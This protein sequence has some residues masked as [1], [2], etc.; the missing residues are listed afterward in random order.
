MEFSFIRFGN[1]LK[2]EW[3]ENR[4]LYLLGLAA[5]LVLL[6]LFILLFALAGDLNVGLQAFCYFVGLIMGGGILCSTLF[7]R[8]QN[9]TS[10]IRELLL[11]TSALERALAII[12]I[13]IIVY[14]VLFTLLF[15]P[16]LLLGHAV[17]TAIRWSNSQQSPNDLLDFSSS[18]I[19]YVIAL[20]FTVQSFGFFCF[21]VFRKYAFVKTVLLAMGLLAGILFLNQTFTKTLLKD[22]RIN[23][24]E[25][26]SDT[27][28]VTYYRAA[29]SGPYQ[30]VSLLVVNKE[31]GKEH[32]YTF[33]PMMVVLPP[34]VQSA[35]NLLFF[36]FSLMLWIV[37]FFKLK[38][39]QL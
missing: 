9:K 16:C 32:G 10:S 11:P 17:D 25:A 33:S 22:K 13:G 20:N 1:L 4:K 29:M 26:A 6:L 3:A 12:L 36:I 5:Y 24:T 28:V 35:F 39:K 23:P 19:R 27:G 30:P 8:Y 15:Y 38:E 37:T 2:K 34:A 21:M 18:S 14:P 31:H 7:V